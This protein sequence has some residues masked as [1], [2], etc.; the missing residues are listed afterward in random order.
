[1]FLREIRQIFFF[2]V[3]NKSLVQKYQW[4]NNSMGQ[5]MKRQVQVVVMSHLE[6]QES[7]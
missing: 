3:T 1:M 5:N 7:E 2:S 6:V 4:Q